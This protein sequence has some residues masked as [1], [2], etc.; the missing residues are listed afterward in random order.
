MWQFCV[1]EMDTR[2]FHEA[3]MTSL[4]YYTITVVYVLN[5]KTLF[6]EK[7]VLVSSKAI[8]RFEILKFGF[9]C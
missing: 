9:P 7:C 3:Q 5:I 6:I 2:V 1:L 8:I 4:V